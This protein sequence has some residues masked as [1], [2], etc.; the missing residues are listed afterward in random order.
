MKKNIFF[1]FLVQFSNYIIPL[2]SMPYII[3][4]MGISNFGIVALSLSII[5]YIN[6]IID[7]GYSFVSVRRASV[8][9]E[10]KSELSKIFSITVVSKLIIFFP[11]SFIILIF[12]ECA[13]DGEY[14]RIAALIVLSGFFSVFDLAWLLQAIEKMVYLA[15]ANVVSRFMYL[16]LLF[17]FVHDSSDLIITLL[18]SIFGT[19]L[20][21]LFSIYYVLK[22]KLVVFCKINLSEIKIVFSESLDIFLS[23]ISISFYTTFNT[24][25]L[26]AISGPVSVG[27]FAAADKIRTAAQGLINPFQQ[28]M[29]PRANKLIQT[30]ASL[31]T[32]I[33]TY[34]KIIFLVG[35]TLSLGLLFFGGTFVD[36]YFGKNFATTVDILK[37]LSLLPFIIS[38]AIV[39]GPWWMAGRAKS[40]QFRTIYLQQSICHLIYAPV[41]IYLFP[42][43]GVAISIVLTELLVAIRFILH[44]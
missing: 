10:S 3:K 18:I 29:F 36:L 31:S 14:S 33:N 42:N 6:L 19:I 13:Y 8:S 25:L 12:A 4:V 1:L 24:I 15:I 11:V 16:G 39:F 40:K 7:F 17:I 22:T 2:I 34:G 9:R 43:V 27:Y 37:V 20:P 35:A 23:N 30:G 44:R 26:G 32:L 5:Q 38:V 28:A 41:L 21:I